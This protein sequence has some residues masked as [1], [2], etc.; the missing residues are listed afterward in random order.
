MRELIVVLRDLLNKSK[1]GTATYLDWL[2]ALDVVIHLVLDAQQGF[3]ASASPEDEEEL[4]AVSALLIEDASGEPA[5]GMQ[6]GPVV[7]I[8][9]PVL[10]KF[11]LNQVL[12]Q[13]DS[14]D[15]S[16]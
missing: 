12:S 7:S 14:N 15:E 2:K 4:R 8:L 11:L 13:V 1:D 5:G 9:L 3:G 6:A 10:L 16:A